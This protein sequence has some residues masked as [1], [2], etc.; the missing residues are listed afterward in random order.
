[1]AISKECK[2]SD[3][4]SRVRATELSTAEFIE[5][6]LIANQPLIITGCTAD[7]LSTRKWLNADG[8]PNFSFLLEQF[9][10]LLE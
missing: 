2:K 6:Y 7:W 5:K 9:G 3:Y 1:M 4:P 8:T 10:K